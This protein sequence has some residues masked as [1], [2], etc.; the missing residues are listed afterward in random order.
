MTASKLANCILFVFAL[1]HWPNSLK[2]FSNF[3][4]GYER[5]KRKL[6]AHGG[7]RVA[8]KKKAIVTPCAVADAC[9]DAAQ[10]LPF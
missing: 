4:T 10:L 9:T 1:G 5:P 3:E 2:N 7:I 8:D 6:F